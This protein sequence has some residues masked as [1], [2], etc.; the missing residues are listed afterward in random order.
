MILVGFQRQHS[1]FPRALLHP[2]HQVERKTGSSVKVQDCEGL[3]GRSRQS[4]DACK[5][6][7]HELSFIGVIP[8]QS[9]VD[10]L[11]DER[12]LVNSDHEQEL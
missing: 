4:Q 7:C 2:L 12:G 10:L 1:S 9:K 6:S 11:I 5:W 3:C 8:L